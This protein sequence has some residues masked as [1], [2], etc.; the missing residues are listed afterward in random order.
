[1]EGAQAAVTYGDMQGAA[2]CC[3]RRARMASQGRI[4]RP[5]SLACDKHACRPL[6]APALMLLCMALG[7]DRGERGCPF[8]T[9]TCRRLACWCAA[10]ADPCPRTK[11]TTPS[12]ILTP[13][14]SL[15]RSSLQHV[16]L[17]F[18]A[19]SGVLS[20]RLLSVR[21]HTDTPSP[22]GGDT[23]AADAQPNFR[24]VSETPQNALYGPLEASDLEWT[25]AGGFTTETQTWYTVLE[26]GAFATS[27]IIHSAIGCVPEKRACM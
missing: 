20:K 1:M 3:P 22:S 16:W 7:R 24:G 25:C 15:P 4:V 11:E 19:V 12:N 26:D 23:S 27:Q 6:Q 21:S 2:H 13:L 10:H 18:M 9:S 8:R 17:G 14:L 5:F